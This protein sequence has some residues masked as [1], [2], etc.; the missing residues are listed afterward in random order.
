MG[1]PAARH[2][3]MTT[4]GFPLDP[5]PGSPDVL[6]ENKPAWRANIDQ[7]LCKAVSPAGPDGMGSVLIGN[8]TVLINNQMACQQGDLV[9]EKPGL[10]MG[11]V[12]PILMGSLTVLLGMSGA[13]TQA[14]TMS[15]AKAAAAPFTKTKCD[16]T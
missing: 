3:D 11:P 14:A 6:I 9:I 10:A 8:P 12:D 5:G 16:Q 4:H 1:K 13:S 15:E 2:L 7:H